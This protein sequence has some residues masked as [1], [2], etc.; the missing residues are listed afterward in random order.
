MLATEHEE[1]FIFE[2]H[3]RF[4]VHGVKSDDTIFHMLEQ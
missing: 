2:T 1:F 3:T 4:H